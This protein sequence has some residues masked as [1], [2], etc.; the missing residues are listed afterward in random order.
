MSFDLITGS[1][2]EV[3]TNVI[4]WDLTQYVLKCLGQNFI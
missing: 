2:V 1:N 3:L 4:M